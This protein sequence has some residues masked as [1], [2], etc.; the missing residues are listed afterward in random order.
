MEV[1]QK[2]V[3][4]KKKKKKV[5]AKTHLLRSSSSRSGL[6]LLLLLIT[7]LLLGAGLL[8]QDR[9]GRQSQPMY[10]ASPCHGSGYTHLLLLLGGAVSGGLHLVGFARLFVRGLV[11]V[12]RLFFRRRLLL[13]RGLDGQL[14][15]MGWWDGRGGREEDRKD[16]KNEWGNGT[17]TTQKSA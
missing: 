8:T 2:I 14:Q 5:G 4:M 16:K 7:A 10:A 17:V 12:L 13:R 3:K 9:Y 6:L 15:A 11:L 1:D